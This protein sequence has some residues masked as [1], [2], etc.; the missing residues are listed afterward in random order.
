[1]LYYTFGRFWRDSTSPITLQVSCL[2]FLPLPLQK[3]VAHSPVSWTRKP[4][5]IREGG[6]EDRKV[7]DDHRTD[8]LSGAVIF[9]LFKN[10]NVP[11]YAVSSCLAFM[12]FSPCH[13]WSAAGIV[14]EYWLSNFQSMSILCGIS[15]GERPMGLVLTL[16]MEDGALLGKKQLRKINDCELD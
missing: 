7:T 4:G 9:S 14:E 8:S 12:K 15:H 1:M 16:R 6:T 13:S 2:S 3:L 5:E 10:T 11:L